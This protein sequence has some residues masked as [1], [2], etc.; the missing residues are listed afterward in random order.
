M[1]KV[2][3]EAVGAS[4]SDSKHHIDAELQALEKQG[5]YTESPAIV[6]RAY[7]GRRNRWDLPPRLAPAEA[8]S[9]AVAKPIEQELTAAPN[10]LIH[11][12]RW[13]LAWDPAERPTAA[14]VLRHPFF[15]QPAREARGVQVGN[16]GESEGF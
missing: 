2:A 13:M 9:A 11:L 10:T 15:A 5:N 7:D 8:R 12:L 6:L 4:D 3:I 14:Q 1:I 16:S